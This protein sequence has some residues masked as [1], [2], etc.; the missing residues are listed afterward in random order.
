[1]SGS[2]VTSM[3]VMPCSSLRRAN[4]CMTSADDRRIERAGRLVGQD[5]AGIV[6][7]RSR[8]RDALLLSARTFDWGDDRAG[9]RLPTS[10]SFSIAIRRRRSFGNA[11]V[12]H[13]QLDVFQRARARQQ[14]VGLKDEAEAAAANVGARVELKCRDVAAFEAIRPGGRRV[15]QPDDLHEGRFARTRRSHDGDELAGFEREIDAGERGDL[16]VA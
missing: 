16:A 7:E 6:D 3:M 15:E 10:S 12:D 4:S 5:Q 8:D 11:G 13:R 1:M 14:V 2:C 9:V